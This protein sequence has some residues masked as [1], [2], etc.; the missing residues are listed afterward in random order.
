MKKILLLIIITCCTLWCFAQQNPQHTQFMYNKIAYNPGYVGSL[1]ATCIT[2]IYR[3]Q[4]LGLEGA[5]ES[6]ILNVEGAIAKN[7]VGLGLH[8][9]RHTIGVTTNVLAATAYSYRFKVG[10]GAL[11]IG[12]QGSFR[13]L[14]N[15]YRD[16]RIQSTQPIG[17]DV[18]IP[19]ESRNKFVPNFGT[20]IYYNTD[21]FYAGFSIPQILE[22][23]IDL[24]DEKTIESSEVRHLYLMAGAVFKLNEKTGLQPQI[25]MKYATNAPIDADINLSLVFLNK[26]TFGAT[27]RTGGDGDGTGESIDILLSGQIAKNLI[28]GFSYDITLSDLN[29]YSTGS[30]E[31]LIRYCIKSSA[32]DGNDGGDG[33]YINPR[34]F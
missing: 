8:L 22:N 4:W 24:T 19:N 9:N 34:F 18:A 17:I 5:P 2:G 6:Q 11:G 33:E 26:Y 7:R 27:Y 25:L 32:S 3:N 13:Y 31:A 28:L 10:K 15:N 30:I 1:E 16:S 14:E 20:G 21:Q 29:N 23:N 12:L